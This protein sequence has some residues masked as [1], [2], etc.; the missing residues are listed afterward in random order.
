MRINAWE[1]CNQNGKN[2]KIGTVSRVSRR[3][4]GC[5]GGYQCGYLLRIIHLQPLM[6]RLKHRRCTSTADV[7]NV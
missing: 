5:F 2:I 7:K 4:E 1:V 6:E 3:N